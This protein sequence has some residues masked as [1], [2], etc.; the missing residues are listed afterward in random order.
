M[1]IHKYFALKSPGIPLLLF[2]IQFMPAAAPTSR[3]ACAAGA[4][5]FV[6][7]DFFGLDF[8]HH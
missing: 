8:S 7:Q 2:L 5:L 3:A 4:S 1:R 6:E